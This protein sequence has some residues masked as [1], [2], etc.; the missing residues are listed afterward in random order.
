MFHRSLAARAMA[1]GP[2]DDVR[3]VVADLQE[4][5]ADRAAATTEDGV[6]VAR[7]AGLDAV[8]DTVES[9][10]GASRAVTAAAHAHGAAVV[11]IGSRG[12]GAARSALLGSVSSGVVQNAELPVLV[13]PEPVSP[14]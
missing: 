5:F 6:A 2:V 3:A 1:S 10:D 4:A 11:A 9:D 14:A 7:A 8:G 12:L 13:V